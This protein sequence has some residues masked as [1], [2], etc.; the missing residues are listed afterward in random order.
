M[1]PIPESIYFPPL[2]RCLNEREL[3][4]SW[5]TAYVSLTDVVEQRNDHLERFLLDPYVK[6]LL[7]QPFDPFPAATQETK[8]AFE[9]KTAAINVTP[10][11]ESTYN[12]TE[13]KEDALW[14]SKKVKIDEISALRLV[15][16]EY[17]TRCASQLLHGF[18]PEEATSL[19]EAGG[20]LN[21]ETSRLL[22]QTVL[23]NGM[24]AGDQSALFESQAS[25][26][27][28]ILQIYLS[29]RRH[30]LECIQI[31][32]QA[33]SS[34]HPHQPPGHRRARGNETD[35]ALVDRLG[36]VLL[37][38]VKQ[39]G[40]GYGEMILS[41]IATTRK[42]ID[43][44]GR[45]SGWFDQDDLQD[46][47]EMDWFGSQL[48]QVVHVL[49]IMLCLIQ[50]E[51]RGRP[52]SAAV[53]LGWCKLV[54]QYD[55]FEQFSPPYPSVMPLISTFKSLVAVISFSVINPGASSEYLANLPEDSIAQENRS[56]DPYIVD[57]DV[58]AELHRMFVETAGNPSPIASP[59]IFGWAIL[60]RAIRDISTSRREAREVR[61]SQRAVDDLGNDSFTDDDTA[62]YDGEPRKLRR[63]ASASSETSIGGGIFDDI[64]DRVVDR[65]SSDD[66]IEFLARSAVDG[67]HVFDFL[68]EIASNTAEMT[69]T[70]S[71]KIR[72][73]ILESV[74][75][76]ASVVGYIPEILNTV[77]SSLTNSCG[78]WNVSSCEE[79]EA[80]DSPLALF[81]YND[82]L[83]ESFL[84]A[85]LSRYPYERL[86]FLKIIRAASASQSLHENG[87]P[88][89]MEMLGSMPTFTYE[90]PQDF[91]DYETIQEE[92]NTNTIQLNQPV[93]LFELRNNMKSLV[94]RFP[95]DS[96]ALVIAQSSDDFCI[97]AGTI[98]RIISDSGPRI[99]VMFHE[100]S[101][102]RYLGKLLETAL[103]AGEF[104]DA[105]THQEADHDSLVEIVGFMAT[106]LDT[107]TKLE[108]AST[109][110]IDPQGP[111]HRLLEEASDGLSRNRDVVSVGFSLF[112]EQLYRL[113]DG[114]SSEATLELLVTLM[115]FFH[116]LVPILPGRVWSFL[117]RSGLL[118][119]DGRGGK[120]TSILTGVELVTNRYD[121]LVSSM[122]LFNALVEDTT[123]HAVLRR[124]GSKTMT[125][126]G[127]I[128]ALGTGVP[129]HILS[130]VLL[131]LTRS[132]VDVF[133]NS[134]NWRFAIPEQRLLLSRIVAST[135]NGIL[136]HTYGVDDLS[137]PATKLV[138]ILAPA[139]EHI[140]DRF[141]SESS[142]HIH[143]QPMLRALLDGL[144]T[145]DPTSQAS[146]PRLWRA[147]TTAVLQFTATLIRLSTLVGRS[148]S[149][150]EKLLFL[151]SPLLARLYAV[152]DSYR[153]PV[154][155]LLK[156]LV[157]SAANG[158]GEP[159]SLLGHLG[160]QT[161]KNFL[162]MISELGKPIDDDAHAITIWKLLS[163]VVSNRQQWFAIF[164]LTGR[165][166][167]ETLKESDRN[168]AA[169]SSPTP[170]LAVAL[171]ELSHIQ[172]VPL[173]RALA[174]LEFISLAQ[175]FWPWAMSDLQKKSN[176]IT[177][178]SDHVERISQVGESS[179]NKTAI[180]ACY[181]TR[182]AAY[183]AEI[184]AMYLYHA[185]Q[186]GIS[187][188]AKDVLRKTGFYRR[189]AVAVPNYNSSLH[190]NLKHN[191]E[192][193]FKGCSLQDF[194]RTSLETRAYGREFYYDTQLAEKMLSSDPAWLGRKNDGLAEEMARANV[195][196]SLVDAQV[197][198]LYGWK[199]L[200]VEL[201]TSIEDA[202]VQNILA[203]TVSDCLI[204]NI[205]T[206]LPENVFRHLSQTRADFALILSQR[207][208]EANC[209]N[210]E[211]LKLL[212]IVWETLRNL[213]SSFEMVLASGD[214][215]YYRTLL[216]ILYL[217]LQAHAGT[218]PPVAD[219][220]SRVSASPQAAQKVQA[221]NARAEMVLEII[222]KVV[223]HGF[224]DLHRAIH[225]Q[226]DASTPADVALITAILQ[227][228][229]RI[230]GVELRHNQILT[231]MASCD[232]ARAATTLFSWSDKL[233]VDGDPIYGELSIQ[234]LLELSS[235]PAMAEQL[236]IEGVLGHISN[237]SITS[238][239]RRANVSPFAEGA[240]PQRCYSIWVRGILPLLLNML[241]AV[242]SPVAMDIAIF[243]NHFPN[244]LKQSVELF[245]APDS[246]RSM[247][248]TQAKH[249]TYST[250]SEIH[251]LA[252]IMYI[253]ISF[254]ES[255]AGVVDIPEV[256]WDA[257][258]ALES[259]EFWIGT[260]QVLRE[261]ILPLSPREVEW[262]K[263]KAVGYGQNRLEEKVVDEL[264]GIR[265]I[266]TG[267]EAP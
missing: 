89:V 161:S 260:R 88:L 98:G 165:T 110:R 148:A 55:F 183:I 158:S 170:L 150:L 204:S 71:R 225:E 218:E 234:L 42:I 123:T 199:M 242:G 73:D 126:F 216:K 172:T 156:S 221:T 175:N 219:V 38:P 87:S 77:L 16:L 251:S 102:L 117:G 152:H 143:F 11:T 105:I 67:S 128:E 177:A 118:N 178:I 34:S 32:L 153:V 249:I 184:L 119:L 9:T 2:D 201:S 39:S 193:K 179:N 92:E 81:L 116:A 25:T 185:R 12:I 5:R 45:G 96:Q 241:D 82:E 220:D 203:K 139:A 206:H 3:L 50:A 56:E 162:H 188:P 256:Q 238:Y 37:T 103:A 114:S 213:N 108:R 180:E 228:S 229:L 223:A 74:R 29:E 171:E 243:L 135:L 100:Y 230:P 164:L 65:S 214:A 112:E 190:G 84:G 63:R 140:I 127:S 212:S 173:P 174:M 101:G 93:Q 131:S 53:A 210:L 200:A 169:E 125:R 104:V 232:T 142:G 154:I 1:V 231:L 136:H 208:I 31:F 26:R 83:R 66:D 266:L 54:K 134:C 94:G 189:A 57:L 202:T 14:L 106:I 248:S 237:A 6:R 247:M 120:L 132:A 28:R 30:F 107:S 198:V 217:A 76:F 147:H 149:Q 33:A 51:G 257:V 68:T 246:S 182:I 90:L 19:Q 138:G 80:A 261:R 209:R 258:G 99:A 78:Y 129:D 22:A 121:F 227:A 215:S 113:T 133:L 233:A 145:P 239:I 58:V 115:R 35:G 69:D 181:E 79:A 20:D 24:P 27:C 4:I 52:Q 205:R 263:Q 10:T 72:Y 195:N 157:V 47:L 60:I 163:S 194:K 40:S 41:C 267:E 235:M 141:L 62:S 192:V 18:S 207:L 15:I 253:L 224:Q 160:P 8:S 244:L 167:R 144:S 197:A 226:P 240:G 146:M 245:E 46:S 48:L 252:L 95:S 168:Q 196:L 44:L 109:G 166:P 211:V 236:A 265:E 186:M 187:E 122:H 36:E 255:M 151:T 64:M 86:P 23:S 137:E 254:R 262:S 13:I 61:Q 155:Q 222:D 85:A 176:F 7:A 250:V 191:F 91:R 124:S 17:Q 259:A 49:E 21:T 159:P 97:P 43:D 70:T 59:A 111:S 75:C 264:T 130:K